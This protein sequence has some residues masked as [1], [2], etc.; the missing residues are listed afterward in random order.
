M[1]TILSTHRRWAVR[2]VEV[3]V[4]RWRARLRRTTLRDLDQ[5]A[6]ADIGIDASEISSITA[7]ARSRACLTRLRIVTPGHHG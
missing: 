6:L 7:E 4:D 2:W 1:Q 5:R 3:I